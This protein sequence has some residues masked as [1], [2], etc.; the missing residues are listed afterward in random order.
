MLIIEREK[1]I[2][3]GKKLRR[4]TLENDGFM[5]SVKVDGIVYEETANELFAV[6]IFNAI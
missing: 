3:A 2:W 5:Y 1:K 6:Q 4:V